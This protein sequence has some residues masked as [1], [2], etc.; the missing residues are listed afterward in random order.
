MIARTLRDKGDIA[1]AY[2]EYDRVVTEADEAIHRDAKYQPTAEAA[3]SE[4]GKLRE[5][6][7]MVI[8]RVTNPPDDLRVVVGDKPIERADWGKP[9]P[10][11]AGSLVAL[12]IAVGR[13]DQRKEL[14]GPPGEELVVS[15]DYSEPAP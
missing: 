10:V 6:L 13:P 3:R 5:K 4:R 11:V 15:F 14:S 7:T 12:G 9:V 8:I 1:Q 2:T